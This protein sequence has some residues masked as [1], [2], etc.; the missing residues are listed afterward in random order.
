MN[1]FKNIIIIGL[2]TTI[3]VLFI[4][5]WQK[6][7]TI[8]NLENDLNKSKLLNNYY[9][10]QFKSLADSYKT[11]LEKFE[12]QKKIV[13]TVYKDRIKTAVKIAPSKECEYLKQRI[14]EYVENNNT[15]DNNTTF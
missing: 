15:T 1:N 11:S 9:E 5:I 8:A 6:N 4:S 12:A 10:L 3:T 13:H 14:K 2:I 7:R